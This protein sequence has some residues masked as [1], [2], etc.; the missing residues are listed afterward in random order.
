M[1]NSITKYTIQHNSLISITQMKPTKQIEL[2][3]TTL[4][5]KERSIAQQEDK[6]QEQDLQQTD[7][8]DKIR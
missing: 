4:A 3:K 7:G 2:V 1:C 8:N 6:R 5:R